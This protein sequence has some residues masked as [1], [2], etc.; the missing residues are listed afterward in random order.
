[1]IKSILRK[2]ENRE[3]LN[4]LTLFAHER[5]DHN[6]AQTGHNFYALKNEEGVRPVWDQA[7][8]I[9]PPNYNFVSRSVLEFIDFDIIISGN[10]FAHLPILVPIGKQLNIPIINI[11]HTCCPQGWNKSN[12]NNPLF[13][14]C[15]HVF[16]G[17][18]NKI[19]WGGEGTIIHHP[20]DTES[21][22][23]LEKEPYNLTVCND[24]VNRKECGFDLWRYITDKTDRVV[25]GETP[26]LSRQANSF[27]E[28]TEIFGKASIYVNTS[29]RSPIPMSLLESSATECGI[30]TTNTCDIPTW[31]EHEK[32][33]LI[34]SP[35]RPQDGVEYLQELIKNDELRVR[36]GKAAR[37]R[38][39]EFTLD[40]FLAAWNEV[41][42]SV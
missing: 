15:K 4:I 23:P 1:M 31:F 16:I 24:F 9:T 3:R 35:S 19:E 29:L 37:K 26:G 14:Q 2:L 7:R 20:V 34:F 13:N 25:I 38:A 30:V 27:Q 39:S 40:K 6:L 18:T 12:F 21:F 11:F 10:G 42:Y 28:L 5:Y 22:K 36:L 41:L 32:T 17:E 8:S 33:A